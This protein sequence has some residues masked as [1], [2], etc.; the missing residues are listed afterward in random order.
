MDC[1]LLV[2]CESCGIVYEYNIAKEC[3]PQCGSS[4]HRTLFVSVTVGSVILRDEQK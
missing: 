2:V 1:A 4:D 3:C